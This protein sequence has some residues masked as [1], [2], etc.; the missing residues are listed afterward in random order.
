[1]LFHC[2]AHYNVIFIAYYILCALSIYLQ[3]VELANLLDLLLTSWIKQ[4][5]SLESGCMGMHDCTTI[6]C[7]SESQLYKHF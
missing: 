2:L 3:Y 5:A 7:I 1:M 6:I 4:L